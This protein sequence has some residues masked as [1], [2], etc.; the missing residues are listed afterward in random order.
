MKKVLIPIILLLVALLALFVWRRHL[1][2]GSKSQVPALVPGETVLFLHLPDIH[3]TRAR[4]RRTALWQIGHE[5]DVRAF[6]AQPMSKVPGDE[7]V[8]GR[9]ARFLRMTRARHLS[10]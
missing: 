4:W 8:K 9:I 2:P 10:R 7:T 6:L 1:L 5:P 3:E